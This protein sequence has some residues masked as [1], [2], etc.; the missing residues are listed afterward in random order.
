MKIDKFYNETF[1]FN[2]EVVIFDSSNKKSLKKATKYFIDKGQDKSIIDNAVETS[3]AFCTNYY[4]TIVIGFDSA[5]FIKKPIEAV[6][7]LAHECT[8]AMQS[9]LED[10][11]EDIT[12]T[13]REVYLRISAWTL[14]KCLS[15]KYF[16]TLFK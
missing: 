8:H 15:V 2:F 13:D 10:I 1:E 4:G 6:I 14:K 9:V 5:K 11:A 12:K 3:D 7:V 16:K